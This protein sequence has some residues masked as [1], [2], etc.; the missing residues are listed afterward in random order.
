MRQDVV[1]LAL[2]D[3]LGLPEPVEEPVDGELLVGVGEG[4]PE[5]DVVLD[6]VAVDGL[7]EPVELD[8]LDEP[9]DVAPAGGTDSG[10]ELRPVELPVGVV[11]A[12]T[13]GVGVVRGSASRPLPCRI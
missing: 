5:P 10:A 8:V 11:L 4:L 13:L 1:L 3:G 12:A 2:G 9:V 6:V 7:L